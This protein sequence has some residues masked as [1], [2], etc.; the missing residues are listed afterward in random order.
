MLASSPFVYAMPGPFEASGSEASRDSSGF[1][2]D[3][4]VGSTRFGPVLFV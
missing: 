3:L 2:D 4:R 1:A